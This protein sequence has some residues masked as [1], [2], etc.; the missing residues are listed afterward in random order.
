MLQI[1]RYLPGLA[2]LHDFFVQIVLC[3]HFYCLE[4]EGA[5]E[6]NLIEDFSSSPSLPH[7]VRTQ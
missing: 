4:P 6:R 2:S 3:N 5:S 1:K 7:F